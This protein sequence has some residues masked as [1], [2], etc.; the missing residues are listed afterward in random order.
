[1][2][3]N[4]RLISLI[5]GIVHSDRTVVVLVPDLPLSVILSALSHVVCTVL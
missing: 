3:K 4:V 2:Q 5:I 1:M